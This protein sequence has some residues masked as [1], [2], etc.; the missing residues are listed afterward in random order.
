[1]ELGKRDGLNQLVNVLEME[2]R[3]SQRKTGYWPQA[4]KEQKDM[5]QL[6]V[7]GHDSGFRVKNGSGGANARQQD[8]VLSVHRTSTSTGG[9]SVATACPGRDEEQSSRRNPQPSAWT[10]ARPGQEYGAGCGGQLGM[11]PKVLASRNKKMVANS[12]QEKITDSTEDTVTLGSQ[13]CQ[14]LIG[15]GSSGVRTGSTTV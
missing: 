15:N 3:P 5:I 14:P 11:T 6:A 2:L 10:W 1:M 7:Q 12:L 8:T 13:D 9:A 4:L